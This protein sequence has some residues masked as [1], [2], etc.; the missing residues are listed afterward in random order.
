MAFQY[1]DY[2]YETDSG[3]ILMIRMASASKLAIAAN[4]EPTGELDVPLRVK[5]SATE[6]EAGLKPR[7]IV[8]YRLSGTGDAQKTYYTR[9]PKLTKDSAIPLNAT[10]SF[11]GHQWAVAK[12]DAEEPDTFKG[13]PAA[14]S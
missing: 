9:I 6:R 1:F 14:S 12:I 7:T 3:V 11:N 5:G 8:G 2:K 10:F 13:V 4:V